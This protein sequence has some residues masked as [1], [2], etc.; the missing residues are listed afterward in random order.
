MA[1]CTFRVRQLYYFHSRLEIVPDVY[2]PS[3][4]IK[5]IKLP[6]NQLTQPMGE[7]STFACSIILCHLDMKCLH[8]CTFDLLDI[9]TPSTSFDVRHR[10]SHKPLAPSPSPS[11]SLWHQRAVRVCRA[12]TSTRPERKL[13][14]QT[15]L[16]NGIVIDVI[17]VLTCWCHNGVVCVTL[18]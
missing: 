16:V 18:R 10:A 11:P 9:E 2:S 4:M 7:P 1:C 14:S 13:N 15:S 3:R 6:F 8:V 5:S 17:D 12:T